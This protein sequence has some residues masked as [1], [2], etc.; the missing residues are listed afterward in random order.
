MYYDTGK[1]LPHCQASL[2]RNILYL[3]QLCAYLTA[4]ISEAIA[5]R[6]HGDKRLNL[7]HC[8]PSFQAD[9]NK[10]ANSFI[11]VFGSYVTKDI[12]FEIL[13]TWCSCH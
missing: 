7:S 1:I 9:V 5:F 12:D 8:F 10:F 3:G 13:S 2:R 11:M 6:C 4:H